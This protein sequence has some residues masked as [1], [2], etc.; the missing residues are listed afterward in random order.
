MKTCRL[1]LF[2]FFISNLCAFAQKDP[3]K[4]GEVDEKDVKATKYEQFPDAEAIVLCDYGTVRF[5]M[6]GDDMRVISEYTRRI[7]IL[8]KAGYERANHTVPFGV[9]GAKKERVSDIKGYT[10]NYE[11]GKV[12]KT[13]LE[14]SAV[15]EK[16][17]GKRQGEVKFLMPNVKEGSVVEYSYE[18]RSDFWWDI[19]TWYFQSNVPALWSEYRVSIPEYYEFTKFS[20]GYQEFAVNEN[21][22]T[23]TTI[24]I[25]QN[26]GVKPITYQNLDNRWVMKDVPPFKDEPFIAS[27]NDH[28]MKIEFNHTANKG[29]NG[30]RVGL[31]DTWEKIVK[32]LLE[33]DKYG[34]YLTKTLPDK[35]I[36]ETLTAGK[37][38]L[39]EKAVA[40]YEYVK[41][42]FKY[43]GRTGLYTKKSLKDVW[44]KKVGS[45]AEINLL[46]VNMLREAGISAFPVISSTR[47]HGKVY[48]TYPL[49][50]KFNYTVVY[51]NVNGEELL[52]DATDPLLSTGMLSY[53]ALNGVGLLVKTV[54]NNQEE[55]VNLQLS[56]FTKTTNL[57]I[58]NVNMDTNGVLKGEL[59]QRFGGYEAIRVRRKHL[60]ELNFVEEED[61]EDE[62][63]PTAQAEAKENEQDK[64]IN[65]LTFKNLQE[66][67]KPLDGVMPIETSEHSQVNDDFI[68]FTPLLDYRMK[69]NPLKSES[70]SF[71][72]DYACATEQSFYMN[73]T[74]PE[75]YKVEELPKPLRIKW[76]DESIKFEYNINATG[77]KI[78]LVSKF[79][80][81]RPVFE[82]KEYKELRDMY[83]QI[84][85]KQEE[86]IVLKKK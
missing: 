70:R 28:I 36:I 11:N 47:S 50:H 41:S 13:K 77:N 23:S 56:K 69:E 73:F 34:K 6:S 3:I 67:D 71:P 66:F 8:T 7:K 12:V 20:Q 2:C 86:Q 26:Q 76:T 82:A 64:K 72:I 1:L 49:L 62:E 37:N 39:K 14:K 60:K 29:A 55:W 57:T 44:E 19:P 9:Y 48:A 17:V 27:A 5:D 21:K 75:G 59:T 52:L 54:L 61:E 18:I 74:I 24:N 43:N 38:T 81:T 42:N 84:V 63:E 53:Q 25:P 16:M 79:I 35:S 46:L 78:Q 40:I 22:N 80:L 10:Y 68:Y 45:N 33:D 32:D 65:K 58:A 4:F 30:I 51:I 31:M 83:A 85:A 15:T